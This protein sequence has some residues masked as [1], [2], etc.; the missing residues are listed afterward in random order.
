METLRQSCTNIFN[1]NA[2]SI[3]AI[4]IST[5]IFW[6]TFSIPLST[7][8]L[9]KPLQIPHLELHP[10]RKAVQHDQEEEVHHEYAKDSL[11]VTKYF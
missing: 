9:K 11:K 6:K 7:L 10:E 2:I 1:K 8:T 3:L 4:A 5:F